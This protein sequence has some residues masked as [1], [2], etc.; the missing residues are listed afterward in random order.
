MELHL[1]NIY[2][3]IEL[4][5]KNNKNTCHHYSILNIA[6]SL[7][8]LDNGQVKAFLKETI[9]HGFFDIIHAL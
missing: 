1:D 2:V 4:N 9:G 3:D 6:L 8:L 5:N 7:K